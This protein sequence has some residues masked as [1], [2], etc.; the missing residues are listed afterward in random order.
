M[1][2]YRNFN[3]FDYSQKHPDRDMN[4]QGLS[5]EVLKSIVTF[6]STYGTVSSQVEKYIQKN[7]YFRQI[8][9]LEHIIEPGNPNDSLY[10]IIKGV[11]RGYIK[12]DGKE[13]TTWINEEGEIVG[14]IRNYG[15]D[16]PSDEYLQAL[17]NSDFLVLP[18]IAIQYLYDNFP[19]TNRIGRLIIEENYRDAEERAFICRL[20]QAEERYRRFLHYRGGLVNR[21]PLKFI[22]NYLNMNLETLSRIRSA[23]RI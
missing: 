19:E 5:K 13:I 8:K 17:E 1:K 3:T 21:I 9:K 15:L 14:S 18:T 16:Q 7:F 12:S 10:F 23:K 2:D 20:P 6:F 4:E 22:A 11:V